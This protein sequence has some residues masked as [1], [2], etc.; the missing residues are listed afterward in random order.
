VFFFTGAS[1][2][3]ILPAKIL[4][5]HLQGSY[6]A[7]IKNPVS[8]SI[9]KDTP[10]TIFLPALSFKK[11]KCSVV[12]DLLKFFVFIF[13]LKPLKIVCFGSYLNLIGVLCSVLTRSKIFFFEP[14][15]I[16]GKGTRLLENFADGIFT[17]FPQTRKFTGRK[18]VPVKIP[19]AALAAEKEKTLSNLKFDFQKPV[20]LVLGGSQG[21]HFINRVICE[22]LAHLNFAQIIHI[23]G[24]RDFDFVLKKYSA[25]NGNH[26]VLPF[27]NTMPLFYGVSKAVVS[28]A[29]AGTLAE[30]SYY[31]IPSLLIPYPQAGGHQEFNALYFKN[32]G[33]G[34]VLEQKNAEASKVLSALEKIIFDDF[35]KMKENLAKINIADDGTALMEAVHNG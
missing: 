13:K 27:T 30:L 35:W 1:G 12:L 6:I 18:T 23:T 20:I 10:D 16:P 14:N 33:G 3:H 28:R 32:S 21:S 31:K 34:I 9:L 5:K 11:L 19:V 25:H 7:A 17:V 29:G 22:V 2:G 15:L 8:L 4:Q 24:N 26:I